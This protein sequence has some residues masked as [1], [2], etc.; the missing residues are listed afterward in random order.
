[1]A[2]TL[3]CHLLTAL[4]QQIREIQGDDN[5]FASKLNTALNSI[6]ENYQL[7]S[8]NF[9]LVAAIMEYFWTTKVGITIDSGKLVQLVKASHL[10][11]LGILVLESCLP[12][13]PLPGKYRLFVLV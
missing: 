9:N 11:A 6:V 1:M 8:G 13:C 12:G 3:F 4:R 2:K 10:Q 7:R 5:E